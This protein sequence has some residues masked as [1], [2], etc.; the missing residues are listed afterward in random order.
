MAIWT[1]LAYSADWEASLGGMSAEA[2]QLIQRHCTTDAKEVIYSTINDI[3]SI[4]VKAEDEFSK[5]NITFSAGLSGISYTPPQHQFL[6]LGIFE[7]ELDGER[8]STQTN[9]PNSFPVAKFKTHPGYDGVPTFIPKGKAT[10]ELRYRGRTTKEEEKL[11]VYG[12]GIQVFD[13]KTQQVLGERVEFFW[14][15]EGGFK[16]GIRPEKALCPSLT[17]QKESSPAS[18]VG[19]VINPKSYPCMNNFIY[20]SSVAYTEHQKKLTPEIVR[21]FNKFT[22]VL[23][24]HRATEKRIFSDLTLCQTQYYKMLE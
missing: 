21:D 15:S 24:E 6:R 4:A 22:S 12:R 10:V 19:R 1:P 20:A 8:L 18:F 2:K 14:L 11:G 23:S 7:I 17:L 5:T 13:T 16:S 9:N 3:H